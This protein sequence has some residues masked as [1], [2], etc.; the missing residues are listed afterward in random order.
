MQLKDVHVLQAQGGQAR[1][2][3]FPHRFRRAGD[4]LRGD[5]DLV[6][7]ALQRLADDLFVLAS[8]VDARGVHIVYAH[9]K[10]RAKHADFAGGAWRPC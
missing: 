7:I 1:L 6:A 9:V 2:D 5:I 8:H 10:R 3:G 4:D